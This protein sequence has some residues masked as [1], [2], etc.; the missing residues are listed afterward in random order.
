[1]LKQKAQPI[2]KSSFHNFKTSDANAYDLISLEEEKVVL[3]DFLSI[4]V[5]IQE[6][7][8]LLTPI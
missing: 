5:P 6:E 7:N 4:E 1:M 8:S 2:V 3:K